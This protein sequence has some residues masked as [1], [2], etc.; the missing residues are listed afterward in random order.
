[1]NTYMERENVAEWLNNKLD[2]GLKQKQGGPENENPSHEKSHWEAL[3]GQNLNL[4][5]P[6]NECLPPDYLLAR[7]LSILLSELHRQDT[8]D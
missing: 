3:S 5:L 7:I 1:M 2:S 6:E 4:K 8:G